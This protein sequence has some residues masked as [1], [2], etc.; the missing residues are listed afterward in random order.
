MTCQPLK[1]TGNERVLV[2][3]GEPVRVPRAVL[4]RGRNRGNVAAGG[5]G[6]P[7]PLTESDW[8]ITFEIG[9][10]PLKEKGLIFVG[11]DIMATV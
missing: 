5:R 7:R 9:P 10:T 3:D 8:K 4:G 11:L 2:V 6:Q 1:E